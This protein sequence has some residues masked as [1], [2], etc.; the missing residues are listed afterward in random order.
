MPYLKQLGVNTLALFSE[1]GSKRLHHVGKN[2]ETPEKN[3]LVVSV[4]TLQLA[5]NL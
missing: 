1:M 2:K 5:P 4:L 3:K